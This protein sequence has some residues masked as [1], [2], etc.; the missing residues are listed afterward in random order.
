MFKYLQHFYLKIHYKSEKSNIILDAL[1]QL[2]NNNDIY[3]CL[4]NQKNKTEI[5]IFILKDLHAN[6]QTVFYM[7]ILMKVLDKL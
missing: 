3:E 5:N 1:F 6:L 2:F 4:V 7:K